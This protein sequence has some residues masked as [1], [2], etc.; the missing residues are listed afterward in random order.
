MNSSNDSVNVK[1]SLLE[2]YITGIMIAAGFA[3][4]NNISDGIGFF[5]D[6]LIK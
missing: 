2:A 5:L 1:I 4:Y 6:Y 3:M